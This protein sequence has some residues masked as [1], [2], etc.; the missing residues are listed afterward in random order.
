MIYLTSPLT[1]DWWFFIVNESL[2]TSMT[3]TSGYFPEVEL[4]GG[5]WGSEAHF[6]EEAERREV[7]SVIICCCLSVYSQACFC[8]DHSPQNDVC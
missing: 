3:V 5:E 7:D 8:M 4:L 6:P 2:S 1:V